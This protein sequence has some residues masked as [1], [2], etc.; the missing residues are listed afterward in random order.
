MNTKF[1]V[2]ENNKPCDSASF[3]QLRGCGWDN[4]FFNSFAD[5]VEYSRQWL[6]DYDNLPD[7]WNGSCWD[8]SGYGDVIEIR[9]V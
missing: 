3:Q 5:A 4:S 9:V 6:G 2:L 7:E 8:Y 1:Q